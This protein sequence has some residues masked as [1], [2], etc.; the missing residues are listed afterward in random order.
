MPH[1]WIPALA[2]AGVALA[3]P[4]AAEL[5]ID[6]VDEA[7]E[8]NIRAFTAL[9]DEAC[10][11]EDW[12]IRRRSRT[13]RDEVRNRETEQRLYATPL[14]WGAVQVGVSFDIFFGQTG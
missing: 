9:D 6:G 13:L 5:A 1:K 8:Q 11:A 4:A 14:L 10:D 7:L 12:L 3:A 2:A